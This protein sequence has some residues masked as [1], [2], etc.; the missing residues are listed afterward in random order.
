[1]KEFEES[2][3]LLRELMNNREK[4]TMFPPKDWQTRV[5][6]LLDKNYTYL[7]RIG[8]WVKA[9]HVQ[10]ANEGIREFEKRGWIRSHGSIPKIKEESTA[11]GVMVDFVHDEKEK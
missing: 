9:E 11:S 7:D 6:G 3:E 1:M 2:L 10:N 8:I 5:I 4:F